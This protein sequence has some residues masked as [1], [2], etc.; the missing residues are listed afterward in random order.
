MGYRRHHAIL[1]S[2]I[3]TRGGH[4]AAAHAKALEIFGAE[5]GTKGAEAVTGLNTTGVSEITEKGTNGTCSFFI[6]PDGSKEGWESSHAG[7]RARRTF[8]DYLDTLTAESG[9]MSSP[10]EWAE[11]MYGDDE[12]E[13]Q[14]VN[15]CCADKRFRSV[16][17]WMRTCP[18]CGGSDFKEV[19][20]ERVDPEWNYTASVDTRTVL[21]ACNDCPFQATAFTLRQAMLAADAVRQT[22]G[23][24]VISPNR[25]AEL[26]HQMV[27]MLLTPQGIG[28]PAAW[29][30]KTP[31]A[32]LCPH[33]TKSLTAYP[34]KPD[35]ATRCQQAGLTWNGRH[36][37]GQPDAPTPITAARDQY[38]ECPHCGMRHRYH[39]PDPDASD[40]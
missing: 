17:P 4:L 30:Y 9:D 34:C 20:D 39:C 26:V 23:E 19:P 40:G 29:Q 32:E 16:A 24:V 12:D 11:V 3:L 35:H 10:L 15:H 25:Y 21:F 7:D 2:S 33:C 18:F 13:A 5:I 27:A 36:P 22:L 6:A 28:S 8:R 37:E 31:A 1:V 38:D 14:I